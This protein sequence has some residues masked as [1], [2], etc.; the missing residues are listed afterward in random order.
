ML[1]VMVM[2][3]LWPRSDIRMRYLLVALCVGPQLL[4]SSTLAI[5]EQLKLAPPGAR[6]LPLAVFGA[7]VLVAVLAA[8]A[9]LVPPPG[10]TA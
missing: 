4:G 3:W 9:L 5:L 1:L 7:K 6:L 8:R 2:L 10:R